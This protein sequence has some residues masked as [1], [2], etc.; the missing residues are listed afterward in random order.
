[1]LD[2]RAPNLKQLS[3]S[4]NA[5]DDEGL[6][7]MIAGMATCANLSSL[8]ISG[9][10]SITEEGLRSLST[11]FQSGSC[12][13]SDL[14]LGNLHID[15]DG[16]TAL[17]D[18][19]MSYESLKSL[20]ISE[21]NIGDEGVRTLVASL[22]NSRLEIL[23]L[24]ENRSITAAGF[25]SLYPLMRPENCSLSN[26][27][28]WGISIEDDEATALAHVLEDNKSLKHLQFEQ[29]LANITAAGWSAFSR[30]LCDTSSINSTFLSNHTLES[31]GSWSGSSSGMIP[32]AHPDISRYL[33]LNEHQS[34]EVAILKMLMSHNDFDMKPLFQWKLK[35]L[36]MVMDW[37][38]RAA[39]PVQAHWRSLVGTHARCPTKEKLCQEFY[40]ASLPT[41]ESRKLSALFKF[42]RGMPLFVIGKYQSTT[43]ARAQSRKRKFGVDENY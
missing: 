16:V 3:L 40:E 29:L 36:P 15:D 37:F 39:S 18:G 20:D 43:V 31:F 42:V 25:R 19:F 17:A 22:V 30:L 27:C 7:A 28:L 13:L 6:Q 8:N 33:W 21:N 32:C 2:S 41:V 23:N 11:L 12:C 10:E 14:Y 34:H 26:I 38:E 9:N 4:E 1:M 5:I 24:T 35:C